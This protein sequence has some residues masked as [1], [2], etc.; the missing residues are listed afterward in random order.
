[1]EPSVCAIIKA[2]GVPILFKVL[3]VLISQ[4]STAF[5]KIETVLLAVI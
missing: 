5:A 2:I 3:N 1:M 4:R